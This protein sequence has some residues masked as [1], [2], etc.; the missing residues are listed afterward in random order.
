MCIEQHESRYHGSNLLTSVTLALTFK[1][2][3]EDVLPESVLAIGL[4]IV[5]SE[6]FAVAFGLNFFEPNDF[7]ISGL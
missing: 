5:T 3:A 4:L 6:T 1:P 2:E 7:L